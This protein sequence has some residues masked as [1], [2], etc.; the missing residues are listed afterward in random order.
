[1]RSSYGN[2]NNNDDNNHNNNDNNNNNNPSHRCS[3]AHVRVDPGRV[4]QKLPAVADC[5]RLQRHGGTKGQRLFSE[6]RQ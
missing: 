3:L 1:M 6:E 5:T 2:G 4:V